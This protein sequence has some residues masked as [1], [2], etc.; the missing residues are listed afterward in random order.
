M[1][2]LYLDNASGT[3]A[4]V[5]VQG[6]RDFRDD[7]AL[8][9]RVM[10]SFSWEK[11]RAVVLKFDG[12]EL[13]HR[14]KHAKKAARPVKT[15]AVPRLPARLRY[16]QPVMDQLGALPAE[17]ANEDYNTSLLGELL[18]ERVW[19]LPLDQAEDRLADDAGALEDWL[20][21]HPGKRATAYFLLSYLNAFPFE[22]GGS[23]GDVLA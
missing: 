14:M 10:N 12:D 15:V 16:L 20:E 1:R 17:S 13:V 5:H 19:G 4:I 11:E 2:V 3:I 8:W 9:E 22:L 23:T 21:K 7:E 6:L 18:R